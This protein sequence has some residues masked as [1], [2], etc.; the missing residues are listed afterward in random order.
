MSLKKYCQIHLQYVNDT[1]T[2]C[3]DETDTPDIIEE[4]RPYYYDIPD[5][6]ID[7]LL[8]AA[9]DLMTPRQKLIWRK[10]INDGI[11]YSD[12]ADTCGISR[13]G[14]MKLL[15]NGLMKVINGNLHTELHC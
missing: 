1:D 11:S 14:V 7:I 3:F 15:N 6:E 10:L 13:Q 2:V 5:Q 4:E 12:V 8:V 9:L